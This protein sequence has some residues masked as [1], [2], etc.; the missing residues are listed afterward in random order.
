MK[1][2]KTSLLLITIGIFIIALVGLVV[3]RS[4]QVGQQNLLSEELTSVELRLKGIQ[5][6]RLSN[7]QEELEK[8]LSQTISQFEVA[9]AMLS[10]PIES[11]TISSALFGIAEAHGVELTEI[12]SPGLSNGE[13]A[14]L[15]F[16]VIP[17]TARVEGD[18]PNLVSFITGLNGDLATGVVKSVKISIPEIAGE[19]ASA[20]IELAVYTYQ[21]E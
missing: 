2:S 4:Q 15:T 21:G 3:V 14:G 1:L 16:S 7:Q 12:S 8:G 19:E 5:L 17:L 10:Q 9:R 11:I 18:V 6:E 20:N 13:L